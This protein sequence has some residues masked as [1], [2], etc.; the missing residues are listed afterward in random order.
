MKGKLICLE[1]G[2]GAGK[3]TQ[4]KATAEWLSSRVGDRVISTREPGGTEFGWK[5]RELLLWMDEDVQPI[6]ELLL[7][8]S[9]RV[10]HSERIIKPALN[11]GDY[12]L[13]D[14]GAASTFAYQGYGRGIDLEV[15]SK[16]N[17]LTGA[18]FPDLTIWL[19]IDPEIGLGRSGKTDRF[20]KE[21]IEFHRRVREGYKAYAA[22]HPNV[23][24]IDASAG[25]E[26]VS[27]QIQWVISSRLFLWGQGR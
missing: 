15:I 25:M 21:D 22:A 8:A 11:A 19:D 9:D 17:D 20:E 24:G 10:Q 4:I 6:A 16:V 3:S 13:C 1:G 5:L 26:E 23:V 2:E 14:R 12:V 18:V 27:Q 7:Y